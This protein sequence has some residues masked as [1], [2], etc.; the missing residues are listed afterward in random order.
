MT[1]EVLYV[2]YVQYV[3]AIDTHTHTHIRR[4]ESHMDRCFASFLI[5]YGGM[6]TKAKTIPYLKVYFTH[7]GSYV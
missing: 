7:T 4:S 1:D 3:I 2:P 6:T 5:K